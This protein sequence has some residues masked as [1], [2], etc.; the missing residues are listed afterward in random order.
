[1]IAVVTEGAA[2]AAQPYLHQL[3]NGESLSQQQSESFFSAVAHGAVEPV[4]LSAVLIALKLKGETADEIAGAAV[5][6]DA[7]A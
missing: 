7:Y 1:M 5:E 6:R 3:L 4:L 2:F